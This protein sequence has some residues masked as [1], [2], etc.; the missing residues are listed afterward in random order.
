[1]TAALGLTACNLNDPFKIDPPAECD[2]ASQNQ[3]VLDVMHEFYLWNEDLPADIDISAYESP[4]SMVSDLRQGV[5]RWTRVSDKSTSDA[6]FMQG[7]FVGLGYKTQRGEDDEVRISFVSDNSPASA[8]NI[9]RG[10][11]IRGVNGYTAEELDADNSWSSVYGP[12]DPGIDVTLDVEHLAT[13]EIETVTIT[14]AWIDIVSIP[15]ASIVTSPDGAKVGYYIMDKFVETTK[16]ELE[17]AYSMFKDN[18]ISTVVI[19]MRYNG[20]G[21]ISVAE[22]QLNLTLGADH[23]GDVAYTFKYNNNYTEEN[24]STKIGKRSNSIGAD[25][26]V[27]LTSSRT[28]SASELVINAMF[29]YANVTLVGGPT[30]GKPVG[31]KSF[32]FC[33][34][35]LFPITFR[36]TNAVGDTDYFDGL[37]ADCY[38]EDDLFH[39]LGDPKEGMLAAALGFLDDSGSCDPQPQ[40]APGIPPK[41]MQFDSVGETL[42]PNPVERMD[43]DSW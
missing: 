13:G 29:P 31:S 20:G 24:Q 4:E 40:P 10:D 26:I 41:L 39:Q 16:D 23:N 36:L 38:A 6:L 42:L 9:M 37:A 3:F 17:S 30:G 27:V 5:D 12:N 28:L 22:R 14:K 32:E 7:K 34:K 35:L 1:M 8:V 15:V 18:G 33:E 2:V 21:L 25:N 43:I 11:V 19:D